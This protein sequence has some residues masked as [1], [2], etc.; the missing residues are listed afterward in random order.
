MARYLIL[1]IFFMTGCQQQ[2]ANRNSTGTSVVC[3]GDSLTAGYGAAAGH[4]YPTLLSQKI[5][6]PVFNAG[7]SGNTTADAL[8]RLDKDVLAHHPKL[9][10]I[11]LGANDYFHGRPEEETIANMEKIIERIKENGAMVVWAE[12][13]MGVLGDPDIDDFKAMANREHILLIPNI[14]GGIIAH[15]QLMYDQIHPNAE[16]YKIMADKIYQHIKDL[17]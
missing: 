10:I 6:L 11:T 13:Q 17:L 16:G 2:I 1:F 15:P 7:V 4:D 12:V 9:V 3:F 14:L 5:N 8:P